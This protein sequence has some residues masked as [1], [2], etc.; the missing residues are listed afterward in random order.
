MKSNFKIIFGA[1]LTLIVLVLGFFSSSTANEFIKLIQELGAGSWI[2]ES[3]R[4]WW[5][6]SVI[7]ILGIY[8]EIKKKSK[9]SNKFYI[10]TIV[11]IPLFFILFLW[12][13]YSPMFSME[14]SF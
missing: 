11:L 3:A 8:F 6:L 14:G 13:A 10:A 9:I 12:G 2:L 5:V 4:Y 7:P 1:L